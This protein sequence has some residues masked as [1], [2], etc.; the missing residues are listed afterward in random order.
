MKLPT[1]KIIII[2]AALIKIIIT[3]SWELQTKFQIIKSG[4]KNL[5]VITKSILILFVL[6][7]D[8]VQLIIW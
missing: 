1:L 2:P 8:Q 5:A 3:V 6:C 7:A 4:T